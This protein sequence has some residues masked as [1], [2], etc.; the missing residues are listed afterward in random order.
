M[1]QITLPL[2][3]NFL[4]NL[5]ATNY[6]KETLYSY[7]KDL[8]VFENFLKEA[9]IDFSKLTKKDILNY[10]AY[11]SSVDRRTANKIKGKQRLSPYSINRM[12]SVL[13]SYLKYLVEMDYPTPLP[14]DAIKMIKA[15]KKK[16]Q[17][18]EFDLLTKLIESPTLFERNKK[19]AIR[20]RAIL[21]MFFATGMRISELVNLK[22]DQIDKEGKI[23]IFG[24]GKKERFSYLTPRAFRYLKEYLSIRHSDSP[25]VFIPYSGL[26]ASDEKNKKI[27]K[28]YIQAKIKKYRELLGINVPTSAHSLRHGFATYLAES[29]ASPAAIQ[30]LLGH[31]SLDTTTRYVHA[32]D[33]F[34]QKVHKKFHPLQ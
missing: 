5:K 16:S 27:S 10:R 23:F 33:K 20:N 4:L 17:V 28:R 12:L 24:K 21:E 3:D 25:F 2:V 34:A 19:V 30:I 22:L 32:S 1:S 7:E 13:R 14:P 11:L 31:E 29:G 9:K 6:S 8:V 26:N 18:A 15:V